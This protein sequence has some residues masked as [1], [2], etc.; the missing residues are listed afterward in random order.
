M[1]SA[2]SLAQKFLVSLTYPLTLSL[3][4]MLCGLLLLVLHRRKAAIAVF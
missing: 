1:Q 2:A 4:T 3:W